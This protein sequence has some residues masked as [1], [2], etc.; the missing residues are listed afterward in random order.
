V[1]ASSLGLLEG[2]EG[3]LAAARAHHREALPCALASGDAPVIGR[4]L[5]G[6]ADLALAAGDPRRAAELLGASVAIRGAEDRSQV[7][8][9]RVAAATRA[10]LGEP[11][12]AEAYAGGRAI[13]PAAEAVMALAEPLRLTPSA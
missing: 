3:D 4:A 9:G 12:F 2:A 8:A 11:E 10:T 13:D 7:D 5:V 6:L 1:L